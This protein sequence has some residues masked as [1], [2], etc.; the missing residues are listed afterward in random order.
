[1][2]IGITG[3]RG[4]IGW[5]LHVFL[6]RREDLEIRGADRAT[7]ESPAALDAFVS[8]LDVVVHLAGMNRGPDAELESVNVALAAA[9]AEA[10]ERAGAT[11]HVVFSSSTHVERDTAYGRSKRAAAERLRAWARAHRGS[12]TT[13]IMPHVFGE[14]GKPF[15]NS[16]VSTFCHQ[17]AHGEE[18]RI[19]VDGALELVHTQRVAE[20]IADAFEARTDRDVR[21][22]GDPIR[23]SELL[24]RLRTMAS[25]YARNVIP[26]L[27]RPLDL[28]LFN[29][30]RSYLF[31]QHYPVAL[32]VHVDPR[33]GLF[34]AVRSLNAGQVFLS[35]TKPGITRG[36][37][38]HTRKVERFLVTRGTGVIRLRKMFER[39][40]TEFH[41]SGSTP[42]Y[43][44]MPT[45]YTHD[46]TNVGSDEMT[47]AFWAHEIFDPSDADTYSEPVTPR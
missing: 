6:S 38:Y 41:V 40:V 35:T 27:R 31:P 9:L 12:L 3:I 17:L 18:P 30:Y 29:T 24:D 45:F 5:H 2:R 28:R 43:V 19:L 10:C 11:P 34:E 25:Q 15:Y 7:F 32:E 1:V 13:L 4:L 46:I 22:E 21:M 39:E 42:Q 8:G 44:D 20:E 16:V 14:F 36:G 23:T 33:G 26:D 37:H 47:T